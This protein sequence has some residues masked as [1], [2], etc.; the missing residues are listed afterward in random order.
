MEKL[1]IDPHT[2][3]VVSGHAFSTLLENLKAAQEAG[4]EGIAMTEHAEAI[5]GAQPPFIV[6]I[7]DGLDDEYFGVR[8]YKGAELNIMH[9]DGSVDMA[10][11]Y[12]KKLEFAIASMHTIVFQPGTLGQNTEAVVGALSNPYIDVIG[13]PGNP[14]YPIDAET[15][16]LAAKNNNKLLEVNNHSFSVRKGSEANCREILRACIKHDVRITVGSDAHF[17]GKVG[18]F[19]NAIALLDDMEFPPELIVTRNKASFDEYLKERA[20]RIR[21]IE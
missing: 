14:V 19:D 12:I 3:T 15:V 16:V 4:L 1:L 21:D 5:P 6:S 20:K 8:L 9:Y 10:P 17:C 18:N 13:H 2:H 11:H 7:A